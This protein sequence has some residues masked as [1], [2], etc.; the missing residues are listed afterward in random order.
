[1]AGPTGIQLP[2]LQGLR[3]AEQMK[4]LDVV[5]SLRAQGLSEVISLP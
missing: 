5:D 1:M 4:L 2:S 3:S